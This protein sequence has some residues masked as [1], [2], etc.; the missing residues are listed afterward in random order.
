MT[1]LE[2]SDLWQGHI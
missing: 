1:I 2:K